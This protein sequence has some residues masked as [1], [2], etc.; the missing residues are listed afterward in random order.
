M[1]VEVMSNGEQ[2]TIIALKEF[3]L[4]A[5]HVRFIEK[6]AEIPKRD[7][8]SA[9][10]LVGFIDGKIVAARNERGWDV[11][12]G[13]VEVSDFDLLAALHRESEEE[14]GV[15]FSMATPFATLQF[16]GR[17]KVML[18]YASDDCQ[19][20]AFTPS[21]DALERDCMT[22]PD[23]IGKYNWKKNIMELLINKAAQVLSSRS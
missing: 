11:P 16:E 14:A 12:G 17:H 9:I 1:V 5:I 6:E 7:E 22:V 4:D 2:A 20:G 21:D 19:L 23:F 15:S 3:I 18:F 8:V 13:H 10:F